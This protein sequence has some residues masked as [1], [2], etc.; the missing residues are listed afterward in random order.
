[1]KILF[2]FSPSITV[3]IIS[4]IFILGDGDSFFDRYKLISSFPQSQYINL[5]NINIYEQ[6]QHLPSQQ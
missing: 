4:H 2:H 5:I 3:T 6:L 1:M